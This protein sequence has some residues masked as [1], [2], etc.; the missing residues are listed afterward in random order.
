MHI[1]NISSTCNTNI[2]FAL[3]CIFSALQ[4]CDRYTVNQ[5]YRQNIKNEILK[6]ARTKLRY[7]SKLKA[8]FAK[9]VSRKLK[10]TL[11]YLIIKGPINAN[12]FLK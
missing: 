10:S 7:C 2:T 1:M 3:K 4:L 12:V 11:F 6:Q 5:F 9:E 8:H